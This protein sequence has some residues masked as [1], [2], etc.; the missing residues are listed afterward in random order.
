[1]VLYVVGI[2]IVGGLA[3]LLW[4]K[5]KS[6]AAWQREASFFVDLLA[7][8]AT[9]LIVGVLALSQLNQPPEGEEELALQPPQGDAALVSPTTRSTASVATAT[10]ATEESGAGTASP[11][12]RR[13]PTRRATRAATAEATPSEATP[14]SEASPTAEPTATAEPSATAEPTAVP[15]TATAAPAQTQRYTVQPGDY[16]NTIAGRFGVTAAQIIA[17]NPGLQADTLQVDQQITIPSANAPS[18]P[19]PT[20]RPAPRTYTVQAG[21]YLNTI[22]ARY[23]VT[24]AQIVAVN[25]GLSSD[26]LQ[27]GQVIRLP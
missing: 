11:T 8:G 12:V 15:P 25:P 16:L 5:Y 10:P 13:S 14:T 9:A 1:M 23:G 24:S 19:P 7:M 6:G 17:A 3:A 20:A 21:D 22:A 18:A 27:I 4:R 2:A 26:N